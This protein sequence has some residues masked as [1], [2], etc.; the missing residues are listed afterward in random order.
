VRQRA[1]LVPGAAVREYVLPA[2]D[3]LRAVGMDV[4]LLAAPGQR[5]E[6]AD[7]RSYGARLADRL[8]AQA[9]VDLLVGL[10]VGTQAVAAA[11]GR[12]HGAVGHLV[13]VGP[14]VDPA[15][16]TAPRLLGRWLRAGRVEPPALLREQAPEWR[17]AGARRLS[18][19]VRSALTVRIEEEL[20]ASSPD[21]TVVHA[22]QDAVTSHAYAAWLARTFPSATRPGRLVV[23]PEATH[24]WPYRDAERFARTVAE[25]AS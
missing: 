20:G 16:R 4:V 22:E 21:L 23:V 18:A 5:G 14:T 17:R 6:P 25:A 7:L 15:A 10:S 2:A 11:A 3:A 24:S 13:L 19:Q 12:A 9:P 1:V 8:R